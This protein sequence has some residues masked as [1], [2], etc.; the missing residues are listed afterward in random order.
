M[1]QSLQEKRQA[2]E[3]A[4]A[5]AR[6]ELAE[7]ALRGAKLNHS[8]VSELEAEISA[9]RSAEALQ[10]NQTRAEAE[11]AK[12]ERK[13]AAREKLFELEQERLTAIAS[14][15]EAAK[16]LTESLRNALSIN[17]EMGNL[18]HS[19]GKKT[20]ASMHEST[21][22]HRVSA[23]LSALMGTI[24]GNYRFKFGVLGW[25]GT[26]AKASDDWWAIEEKTYSGQLA[27]ITK[28]D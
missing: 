3:Q 22:V 10:T 4:L 16:Q 17:A 24:G 1:S 5:T 19:L 15:H 2:A 8:R 11:Q 20:P 25:T 18:A 12:I 27:E 13:A 9:L 23:A 14:A 26:G 7:Q 28:E 21:F 6:H